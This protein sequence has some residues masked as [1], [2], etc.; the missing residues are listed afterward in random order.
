MRLCAGEPWPIT[1]CLEMLVLGRLSLT[2]MGR[3]ILSS[4]TVCNETRIVKC[5]YEVSR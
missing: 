2:L 5:I 4:I 3:R 1:C